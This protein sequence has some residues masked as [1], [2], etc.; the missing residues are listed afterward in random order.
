MFAAFAALA[1]IE[2]GVVRLVRGRP[3]TRARARWLSRWTRRALPWLGVHVEVHGDVPPAGLIASNHLGYLDVL[4][5]SAVATPVFVSK[6]EVAGWPLAGR[7]AST[8]GTVFIDRR[9][10]TDV[11][12]VGEALVP[13][14]GQGQ[15]AV[16]FL[17]GTSTAGDRLLPFRPS[18][19]EPAVAQRWSVTPTFLRYT[20][21]RGGDPAQDVCY[22]GDHVFFPHLLRMLGHAEIR[23]SVSFGG[24]LRAEGIPDRR[25]LARLLRARVAALG[26]AAGVSGLDATYAESQDVGAPTS[27]DASSKNPEA[28]SR[29]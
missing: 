8:A 15:P 6:H 23:A 7:L 13:I 4:V 1:L 21:P 18:L 10:R 28:N 27:P 5:L 11:V 16:V 2:H 14:V 22:W 12:R 3:D 25:E 26:A 29:G 17:E 24:P 9:K 19:L 20:L